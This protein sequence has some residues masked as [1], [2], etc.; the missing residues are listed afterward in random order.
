MRAELF[1]LSAA[2]AARYKPRRCAQC[3]RT[4]AMVDLRSEKS[5]LYF[6]CSDCRRWQPH[7]PAPAAYRQE[8]RCTRAPNSRRSLH[9]PCGNLLGMMHIDP[10]KGMVL[11]HCRKCG[12][13]D[14]FFDD[15]T[16]ISS[17]VRYASPALRGWMGA[18]ERATVR[19][20]PRDN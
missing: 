16:G 14:S 1:G 15:G 3:K 4:L 12:Q 9:L 19:E 6:W 17:G 10:N 7:A 13:I 5:S 20:E 11:V 18:R 8:I 2:D